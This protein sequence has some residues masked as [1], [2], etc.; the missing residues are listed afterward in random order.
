MEGLLIGELAEKFGL[1]R[2]TIRYYESIGLLHKP[3]RTAG[4]YRV[5]GEKAAQRLGFILQSKE[6]GLRLDEIKEIFA[7]HDRGDVPC[8]CTERLLSKKIAEIDGKIGALTDI[9]KRLTGLLSAQRSPASR[10]VICPIIE[11]EPS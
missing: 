6:L 9:K 10:G 5:Y 1:N 2:K 11:R 8:R 7:A 3:S 4:G